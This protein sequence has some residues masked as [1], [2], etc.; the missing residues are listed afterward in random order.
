MVGSLC[1]FE[2]RALQAG[3]T[4]YRGSEVETCLVWGPRRTGMADTEVGA[5]VW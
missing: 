4:E 3:G 2:R 5:G 1:L